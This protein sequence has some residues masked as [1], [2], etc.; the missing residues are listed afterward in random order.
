VEAAQIM[1][2]NMGELPDTHFKEIAFLT[3]RRDIRN[4]LL[5]LLHE[6][7]KVAFTEEEMR[8]IHFV[9]AVEQ[10]YP[11]PSFSLLYESLLA[12]YNSY[13]DEHQSQ[14]TG[15]VEDIDPDTAK[16]QGFE[17]YKQNQAIG[18]PSLKNNQIRI[19]SVSLMNASTAATKILNGKIKLRTFINIPFFL[20]SS[21]CRLLPFKFEMG[22]S[23]ES[24]Y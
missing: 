1:L 6:R 8:T 16:E 3:T 22:F 14:L 9:S 20:F 24:R 13:G 12:K 2:S 4:K 23:M 18:E 5:R 19:P 7:S 11:N 17:I 21:F 10:L 15:D